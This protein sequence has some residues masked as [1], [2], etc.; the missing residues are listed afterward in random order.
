[1]KE[2]RTLSRLEKSSMGSEEIK[3][4]IFK[5]RAAKVSRL[6]NSVRRKVVHTTGGKGAAHV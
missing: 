1:M 2:E 3:K 6:T 4:G 5:V